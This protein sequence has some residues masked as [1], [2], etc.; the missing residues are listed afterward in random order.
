MNV[1][2]LIKRR[3]STRRYSDKAVSKNIVNKILDAGVWGPA[4][5]HFQPWKFLVIRNRSSIAKISN[6]ILQKIRKK[7]IPAFIT[8]PTASPL[9]SAQVLIF[10]YNTND[11]MHAIRK[12]GKQYFNEVEITEISAISAAIQNMILTA[13]SLGIG[14]CWLDAPLFCQDKISRLLNTNYKLVAVLTIGYPANKT[15]RSPRKP[16]KESIRFMNKLKKI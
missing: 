7:D 4:I 1:L 6:L 11:F 12:M 8:Y 2:T 13:E 16:Y 5:H 10:V 3:T 15:K 14:S 9:L